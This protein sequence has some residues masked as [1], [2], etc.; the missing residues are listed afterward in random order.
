MKPLLAA[1]ANQRLAAIGQAVEARSRWPSRLLLDRK[2]YV[3]TRLETWCAAISTRALE[4]AAI[5]SPKI[6]WILFSNFLDSA[7]LPFESFVY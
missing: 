4:T 3:S 5:Q 7:A 6:S 2:A 1:G